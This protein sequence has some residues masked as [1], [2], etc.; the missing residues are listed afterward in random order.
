MCGICAIVCEDEADEADAQ[1]RV[2]QML[3]LLRHRG[4][5]SWGVSDMSHMLDHRL[6]VQRGIGMPQVDKTKKRPQLR[7]VMGHT[8]YTTQGSHTNLEESQPLFNPSKTIALV[9]NG[10]VESADQTASDTRHILNL[11]CQEFEWC[12]DDF[13]SDE[14]EMIR[15]YET[16]FHRIMSNLRG[17]YA[18]VAQIVGIG[19]FAFRDPRGIRPLV[20]QRSA[21]KICFASESCAFGGATG[22]AQLQ[23]V[24]PGEV[25]WVDLQGEMRRMHPVVEP[26]VSPT[27]CLFEFIYLAH[28]DSCIDGIDVGVAREAMGALL[29]DKVKASGLTIDVIVPVP[30]TPVLAGRVLAQRLGID[31]VEALGVVSKKIRRESRTFILPTQTARENAVETKFFIKPDAIERCKNRCILLLDDSI[32]R[33][34]T[35]RHVVQLLRTVTQPLKLYVASLA[36]P[37]ISPNYFGIDIP[38]KNDLIAGLNTAYENLPAAVQL[39]IGGIDAPVIYQDLAVLKAGLKTLS[40]GGVSDFEDSVFR[41][42]IGE[43]LGGQF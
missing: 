38:S 17:S 25:I 3:Q 24:A 28:D 16:R 1:E 8:R 14:E 10:Q 18:C 12:A 36:P 5:D 42:S 39:R 27:P 19:M 37:I 6:M 32:V 4:Y 22:A 31:F 43:I 21:R 30:H 34:T 13:A 9:H 41:P 11:L 20:F 33:G 29:V 35:L 26:R 7:C 15:L 2:C 40:N 23:N